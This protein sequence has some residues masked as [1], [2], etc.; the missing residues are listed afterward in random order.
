MIPDNNDNIRQEQ[1]REM[2]TEPNALDESR[3]GAPTFR[4][5][6]LAGG[7]SRG[8]GMLRY[9]F[10]CYVKFIPLWILIIK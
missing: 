6:G 1:M 10:R 7:A 4:R 5:G 8:G 3:G 2:M 9:N